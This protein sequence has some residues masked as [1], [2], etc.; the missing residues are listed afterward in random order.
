MLWERTRSFENFKKW[1]FWTVLLNSTFE[2]YKIFIWNGLDLCMMQLYKQKYINIQYKIQK[3]HCILGN[4]ELYLFVYKCTNLQ[5]KQS[6][7][8]YKI[9]Y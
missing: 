3:A 8:R 7:E 5:F 2:F 9:N 4:T 1:D 6:W